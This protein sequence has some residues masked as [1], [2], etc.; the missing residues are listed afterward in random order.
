MPDENAIS[1]YVRPDLVKNW[2]LVHSYAP[3]AEEPVV[4]AHYEHEHR[5]PHRVI[6]SNR[7]QMCK[8]FIC[9]SV[10]FDFISGNSVYRPAYGD[11]ML[12]R[13]DEEYTTC[14]YSQ[15]HVDYY[16]ISFPVEFF[17]LAAQPNPCYV[18]FFDQTAEGCWQMTLSNA[19]RERMI[20]KLRE[21]EN[22]I[23]S[24]SPHVDVLAYAYILQI[25]ELIA[26]NAEGGG[27]LV[28]ATR[29]P[30]KLKSAIDY[31][32]AHYLI[33]ISI[34]EVAAHCGVTNTYLSR[35][36]KHALSCTPNEYVTNLRIS[37]AKYLLGSGSSLTEACYLSGFNNYNY[38]ITKF[39]SIAGVT[40]AQFKKRA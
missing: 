10:D 23:E 4:F 31:I 39:K 11:V 40:P 5:I 1:R 21:I 6:Y 30:D 28:P 7:P 29:I 9:L 35:I 25:M 17:A 37:H 22:L 19:G 3:E 13:A 38:F 26:A 14:F 33:I 27:E 16:D 34:A 36:F 12:A 18:P 15:S 24:Q 8:V 2:C 32:H 20:G